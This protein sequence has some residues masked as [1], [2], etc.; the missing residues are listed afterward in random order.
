L[1]DAPLVARKALTYGGATKPSLA[2]PKEASELMARIP[3]FVR[4]VVM[5]RVE[6]FARERGLTTVT[7]EMLSEIRKAMP[8]DF[9]KRKPFFL[10]DD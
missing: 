8:V 6:D 7:P 2:G 5:Q 1:G 4:G 10:G 9:S 3:S